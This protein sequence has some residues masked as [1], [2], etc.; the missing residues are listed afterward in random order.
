MHRQTRKIKKK[1]KETS[2]KRYLFARKVAGKER[3]KQQYNIVT[4]RRTM[5]I[6]VSGLNNVD[7]RLQKAF[8]KDMNLLSNLVTYFTQTTLGR[9]DEIKLY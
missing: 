7:L 4:K 5:G 2:K 9:D 1:Q 6:T 8:F 3:K